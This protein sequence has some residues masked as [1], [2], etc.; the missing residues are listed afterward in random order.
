MKNRR[1]ISAAIPNAESKLKNN[2]PSFIGLLEKITVE[3]W[4]MRVLITWDG[5]ASAQRRVRVC[6][7]LPKFPIAIGIDKL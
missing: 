3:L 1:R 5:P 2:P 7:S 6:D 4:L